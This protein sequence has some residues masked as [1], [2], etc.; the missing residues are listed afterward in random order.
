MPT[1]QKTYFKCSFYISL[2]TQ[3]YISLITQNSWRKKQVRLEYLIQV[4][5]D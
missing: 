2:I 5:A 4:M 1:A 3:I